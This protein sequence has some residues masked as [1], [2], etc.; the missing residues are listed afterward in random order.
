MINVLERKLY[1]T[2]QNNQHALHEQA[3]NGAERTL[4]WPGSWLHFTLRDLGQRL[5]WCHKPLQRHRSRRYIPARIASG[6]LLSR[7]RKSLRKLMNL[8]LDGGGGE[9]EA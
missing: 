5:Q 2:L 4:S 9:V 8:I 1:L 3:C 7:G 6:V